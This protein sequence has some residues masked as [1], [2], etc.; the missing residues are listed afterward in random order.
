[1]GAWVRHADGTVH[2][3]L[4][5]VLKE[6][7]K[8]HFGKLRR[9]VPVS[10][11]ETWYGPQPDDTPLIT[12]QL[13]CMADYDHGLCGQYQ[14]AGHGVHDGNSFS[15]AQHVCFSGWLLTATDAIAAL[16]ILERGDIAAQT[17]G[18]LGPGGI[19]SVEVKA[20]ATNYTNY[21]TNKTS[22]MLM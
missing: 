9:T 12:F 22:L 14:V 8:S 4:R 6:A 13:S 5:P 3:V 18:D 19:Y 11:G 1:M 2:V 7:M 21:T 10:H 15:K 20:C 17:E 16:D